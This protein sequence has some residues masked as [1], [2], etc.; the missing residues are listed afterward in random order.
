MR[1]SFEATPLQSISHYRF[2]S[3]MICPLLLLNSTNRRHSSG[4]L[5]LSQGGIFRRLKVKVSKKSVIYG[6][7]QCS[8]YDPQNSFLGILPKILLTINNKQ[9]TNICMLCV[10]SYF[11]RHYRILRLAYYSFCLSQ[12]T[13]V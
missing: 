3:G 11:D 7:F 5:N 2:C 4:R 13:M 12:S 10:V 6:H 9:K 1:R 8:N